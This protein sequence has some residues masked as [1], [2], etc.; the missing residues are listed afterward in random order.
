MTSTA[1]YCIRRAAST[2][3][4][5]AQHVPGTTASSCTPRGAWSRVLGV[6]P[7]WSLIVSSRILR[8]ARD[9]VR[10]VRS[11]GTFAVL[12]R[13]PTA[14]RRARLDRLAAMWRAQRTTPRTARSPAPRLWN[15]TTS[16]ALFYILP[17]G[18]RAGVQP[19][20]PV[21]TLRA[22]G[23]TP[24]AARPYACKALCALTPTAACSTPTGARPCAPKASRVRT[25]IAPSFTHPIA[26]F[27]TTEVW[28][29]RR[30]MPRPS[31]AKT[32]QVGA[33]PQPASQKNS[34]KH[35]TRSS[36]QQSPPGRRCQCARARSGI[37]C[38]WVLTSCPFWRAVTSSCSGYGQSGCSS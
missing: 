32:T 6:A 25:Q 18:R 34:L 16:A 22:R 23:C 4:F 1:H 10:P 38:A 15:V 8:V 24:R 29:N 13:T 20:C 37:C 3:A 7:V 33:S 9:R 26:F 35:R 27:L 31:Q 28:M 30:P 17:N 12:A 36:D 21:R 19:G 5:P 11:A 14:A 2:A